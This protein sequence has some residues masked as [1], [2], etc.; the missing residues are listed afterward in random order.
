ML[1]RI[2]WRCQYGG[3]TLTFPLQKIVESVIILFSDE[4]NG[5]KDSLL[6]SSIYQNSDSSN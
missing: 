1:L 4:T 5:K 6:Q 3:V 2:Q